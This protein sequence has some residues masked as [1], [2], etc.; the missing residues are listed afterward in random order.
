MVLPV[1]VTSGEAQ[2]TINTSGAGTACGTTE[3]TISLSALTAGVKDIYITREQ[4]AVILNNFA[5]KMGMKLPVVRDYSGFNDDTD[6]AND[7]IKNNHAN[8]RM[9]GY[10]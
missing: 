2:L 7:Y 4:L 10:F 6:I 1:V 8:L 5:V 3:Q 9:K